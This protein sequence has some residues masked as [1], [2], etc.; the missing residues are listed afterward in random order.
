MSLDVVPGRTLEIPL[1]VSA[2]ELVSVASSSKDYW[3]TILV[4]LDSNGVP[5]LGADDSVKYFA[6]FDWTTP[7]NGIYRLRI[8]F[9]EG[10][11]TGALKVTR[12]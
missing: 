10:V 8:T 1:V 7:A 12:K 5:V 9:F 6:A 11:I 3:D 4:L 2:G